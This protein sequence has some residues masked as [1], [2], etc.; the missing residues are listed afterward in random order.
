MTAKKLCILFVALIVCGYMAPVSGFG[1]GGG[2]GG[3]S[4]HVEYRDVIREV[5]KDV[6]EEKFNGRQPKICKL[7]NESRVDKTLLL[8]NKGSGKSSVLKYV[9][10]LEDVKPVQTIEDGTVELTIHGE[11]I[12]TIGTDVSFQSAS[13][14]ILSTMLSWRLFPA[15][16]IMSN[17]GMV[18]R[19]NF[20]ERFFFLAN[21]FWGT[22]K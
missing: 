4:T 21:F 16:F 20:L 9:F 2:G 1:G 12:D 8:G 18:L 5:I 3:G 10:G 14:L 11:F 17:P 7:L 15:C 19:A 13:K 22:P 6:V